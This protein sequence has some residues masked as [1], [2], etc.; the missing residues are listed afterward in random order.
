MEDAEKVDENI[1]LDSKIRDHQQRI[2]ALLAPYESYILLLERIL[3]WELPYVSA[4]LI[5]S[6]HILFWWVQMVTPYNASVE[7]NINYMMIFCHVAKIKKKTRG[8]SAHLLL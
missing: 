2:I 6:V 3:V 4:A 7:K 5:V 1:S 8:I